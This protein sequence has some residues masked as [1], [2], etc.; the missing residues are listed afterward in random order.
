[1]FW[2]R[3]TRLLVLAVLLL[4]VLSCSSS[5]KERPGGSVAGNSSATGG[6]AVGQGGTSASGSGSGATGSG[7]SFAGTGISTM[8]CTPETGPYCGDSMVNQAS[9]SCDD[10]NT[11]P[12]DGCTGLCAKEPNFDCPAQGGKCQS[13]LKCGDG[14]RSPGEACDDGNTTASDG[15]S[16]DCATLEPGWFCPTAGM[17]CQRANGICGDSRVQPGETCDDGGVVSGDGCS[18]AC[19]VEPGFRCTQP[20]KPCQLVPVCG[21]GYCE[22]GETHAACGSDCCELVG[23]ACAPMCGNGSC[24]AGETK[25]SCSSDCL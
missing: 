3:S 22:A 11:L 18:A 9:E 4:A 10:G 12:G 17:P 5:T 24:E 15:C 25:K 13:T 6:Q 23:S 1:M 2:W 7:I 14:K 19:R 16:A 20:G 21:N 8:P